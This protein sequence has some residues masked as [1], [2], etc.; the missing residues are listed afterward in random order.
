MA[1]ACRACGTENPDVARFCLACGAAL[2]GERPVR[3]ERKF[4]AALFADLVGS[5][6]LGEREDPEIVQ[7]LVGGTFRRLTEEVERYGGIVDKVMGDAILAIFGVPATH[8]DDPER[9]VRAALE[10]Q[11]VLAE[12]NRAVEAEGR[13]ALAMR[14][15]VEAGEVLVHLEREAG[16]AD[17]MLTGD[18]VNTAARLQA[19]AEPGRIVVGP[20]VYASTRAVVDYREL[21]PLQ[22]KGKAEAVPAWEAVAV[23]ARRGGERA[24]LGLEARLVGRDEEMSFL[25]DTFHRV[26]GEGRPGLVTVIGPA[27]V[28]KSRLV[29][30]FQKYVE[31]L[32]DGVTWRKGRCLAYGNLPYSARVDAVKAEC[33]IL[34]DDPPQVVEDKVGDAVEALFGARDEAPH[35]RALVRATPVQVADR[36]DLFESWRRLLERMAARQPLALVLEDIHWADEGLFDFVDHV[37]DLAVG[38]LLVLTIARPELLDRRPMWGGGKRNYAAIS[39]D[40]LT[41]DENAAMLRDLLGDALPRDVLLAVVERAEGNPLFTEEMVRS[42]MDVGVLRPLAGSGWELA[43]EPTEME[44]PRSIH[45][46]IATRLDS[47][48]GEEKALLQD[49][50][51][52]GRFFWPGAVA[53]LGARDAG[54]ARALLGRLRVKELIVPREPS[55]FAGE[56]EFGFRHVLI[57]DVAYDSLPKALRAAK[58]EEVA[59]WAEERAGERAP[60]IAGLLATHH[61]E[62]V[63]YLT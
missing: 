21:A 20:T 30:E 46:L 19:A 23:K 27:G 40:A 25:K 17:R 7:T 3:R 51:V 24:P 33:G 59:R 37:A 29:W 58:H 12:L 43:R 11:A 10:M 63:R 39:L 47:L 4:A 44:L 52:I 1:Q 54:E 38:P 48:P 15:G 5:T 42:F 32:P 60:E 34:E 22:L 13:P 56:A 49:A 2:A 57:R 55:S 35:V 53:H 8:E 6:S 18:A 45:G 62:A 31:G 41:R 26:R 50:A 14:I 28:G 61:G 9:A 16:L 36:D